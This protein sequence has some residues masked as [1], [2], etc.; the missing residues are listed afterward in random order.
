[1]DATIEGFVQAPR[2]LPKTL[3]GGVP[4]QFE[5]KLMAMAQPWDVPR[6]KSIAPKGL[7]G[8]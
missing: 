3:H 1:M 8:Y 5:S 6:R 7:A 2:A 4:L